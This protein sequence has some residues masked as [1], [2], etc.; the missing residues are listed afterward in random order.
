MSNITAR[1]R[2]R[3]E[4]ILVLVALILAGHASAAGTAPEVG[5]T[6][7]DR[8]VSAPSYARLSAPRY[9]KLAWLAAQEGQVTL[10][11]QVDADG[12]ASAVHVHSTRAPRDLVQAAVASVRR[13]RFTPPPRGARAA[14]CC[15]DRL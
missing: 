5:V 1:W 9:P 12:K 14:L 15:A 10:R 7:I 11:V 13:W 4:P 3:A 6:A 2:S 8:D